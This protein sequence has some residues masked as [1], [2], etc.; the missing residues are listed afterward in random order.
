MYEGNMSPDG[1][2]DGFGIWYP[3]HYTR[4]GWF[5]DDSMYGNCITVRAKNWTIQ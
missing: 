5:K 2:R 4:I 3:D 1:Q